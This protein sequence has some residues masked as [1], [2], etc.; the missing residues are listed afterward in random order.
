ME[1]ERESER[2]VSKKESGRVVKGKKE[3]IR[4]RKARKEYE[5]KVRRE[6]EQKETKGRARVDSF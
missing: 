4:A 5:Q 6:K 1:R 3:G 2:R